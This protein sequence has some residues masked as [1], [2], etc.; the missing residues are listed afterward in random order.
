[1]SITL[2]VLTNGRDDIFGTVPIALDMLDAKF[3]TRIIVDDSGDAEFRVRLRET[4]GNDFIIA[5]TGEHNLGFTQAMIRVMRLVAELD[6]DYCF[7]LEEDFLIEREVDVAAMV[8]VI[9]KRNLLQMALLRGPWWDNEHQAGGVIPAR[10]AQGG[11]FHDMFDGTSSWTEHRDHWTN[12]P[13][14]FPAALAK[15]GWPSCAWS[16]STWG[17]FLREQY[18]DR[19]FAYWGEREP[20]IEHVGVRTGTGY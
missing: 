2:V 14:V 7:L 3:N 11:E 16:E 1:M 4:F 18:P 12:N 15:H 13:N 19:S 10:E 20:W 17:M 5:P 6:T 9:E 8:D